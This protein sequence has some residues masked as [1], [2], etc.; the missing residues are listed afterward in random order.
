MGGYHTKTIAKLR[1]KMANMAS[2]NIMPRNHIDV[3]LARHI[4]GASNRAR[5]GQLRR[6]LDYILD[7]RGYDGVRKVPAAAPKRQVSAHNYAPPTDAAVGVVTRMA[8]IAETKDGLIVLRAA[9]CREV[10]SV[11]MHA[12]NK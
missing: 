6:E 7:Q 5:P 1:D 3:K 4:T 2:K 11:I 8:Q 9:D 10:C 12:G